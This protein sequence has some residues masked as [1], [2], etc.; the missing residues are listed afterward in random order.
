M[1][2]RA[3]L[4]VSVVLVASCAQAQDSP[5]LVGQPW[6]TYHVKDT[7]KG[8]LLTQHHRHFTRP[9]VAVVRHFVV[10]CVA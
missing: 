7:E 5:A 2:A 9:G 10:A 8:R 4:L 6:R 1:I 3:V